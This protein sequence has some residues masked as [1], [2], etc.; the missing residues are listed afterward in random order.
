M[1]QISLPDF[2]D[3]QLRQLTQRTGISIE[4]LTKQY[5][6][7]F[8]RSE[9]MAR[10]QFTN[11][12]P[13]Q[14]LIHR[15][16]FAILKTWKLNVNRLPQHEVKFIYTG[17]GGMRQSRR[18]KLYSNM[19]IMVQQPGNIFKLARMVARSKLADTYQKLNLLTFYNANLG[20]HPKGDDYIVDQ[21]TEFNKPQAIN[22][23]ITE[24]NS[25]LG[26]PVVKV[27][28]AINNPSKKRSDG[29]VI[30]TDWRCIIGTFSGEPRTFADKNNPEILRGVCNILD[31]TVDEEPTI[32]QAGNIIYPG[33]TSWTAP[34]HL[35]YD[36]DS[37]CAFYGTISVTV[38]K[39]TNKKSVAFNCYLIRPLLAEELI[40]PEEE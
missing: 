26:I 17:H 30:E 13:D 2:V 18:G 4:D 11:A 37:Y 32:D 24:F 31:E 8:A 21:L 27:A 29:Y 23:P 22:I 19:F 38:D 7:E 25:R 10:Q 1:S 34:E 16:R 28:D 14:I 15:Q 20:K 12:S 3:R 5:L 9:E 39:E 33:L 35:I 40:T 36:E 6:D